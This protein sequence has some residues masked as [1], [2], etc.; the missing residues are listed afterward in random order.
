[1]NEASHP[2]GRPYL[3]EKDANGLWVLKPYEPP[4]EDS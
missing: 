1:M 2:L 3:Y 4:K